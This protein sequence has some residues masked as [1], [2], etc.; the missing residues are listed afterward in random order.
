MTNLTSGGGKRGTHVHSLAERAHLARALE[1]RESLSGIRKKKK[2]FRAKN[3]RP[4]TKK[5][6]SKKI[7]R[8][9]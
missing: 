3:K 4:R 1:E 7:G 8:P 2:T 5:H 9:G 6:P